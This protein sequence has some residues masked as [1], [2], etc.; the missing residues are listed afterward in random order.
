MSVSHESV[1]NG[2]YL[3]NMDYIKSTAS[4]FNHPPFLSEF[5]MFI[6][7]DRVQNQ[8]RIIEATY[9]GMEISKERSSSFASFYSPVISELNG[10][11]TFIITS[12]VNY[13]NGN[14]NKVA[15]KGD[16]WNNENF[17]I[18]TDGGSK[19]TTPDE[20]VVERA[21]PRRCQGR[22]M[23]FYY[24]GRPDD[25][26]SGRINWV[27]MKFSKRSSALKKPRFFLYGLAGK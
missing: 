9:Q 18:V 25:G 16:A 17:S 6:K 14:P 4:K 26:R 22:I 2:S 12:I 13:K 15:K 3:T 8:V 1:K 27:A 20:F 11:G 10:I 19:Y 23:H 5:G 7:K 24:K 21:W